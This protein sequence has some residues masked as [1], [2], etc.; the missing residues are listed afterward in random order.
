MEKSPMQKTRV[1]ALALLSFLL[2]SAHAEDFP[3]PPTQPAEGGAPVVSPVPPALG[4]VAPATG[5]ASNAAG[6]I[7]VSSD[8]EKVASAAASEASGTN[9]SSG[10][11]NSNL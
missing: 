1:S 4:D 11:E 3:P 5:H 2:P 10:Q 7:D 8:A 9:L 6:P